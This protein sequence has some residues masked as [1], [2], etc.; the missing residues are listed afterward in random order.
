VDSGRHVVGG[1]NY[2]ERGGRSLAENNGHRAGD[3]AFKVH[4]VV[5]AGS[6]SPAFVVTT[7]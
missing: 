3:F 2:P 7:Q 4:R 6:A 1:Q 5:A